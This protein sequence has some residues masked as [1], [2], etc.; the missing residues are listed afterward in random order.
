M[1]GKTR[2]KRAKR[3]GGRKAVRDYVRAIARVALARAGASGLRPGEVRRGDAG[4]CVAV[5]DAAA[6]PVREKV[7][8][9]DL[10]AERAKLS[11]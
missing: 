1:R 2:R 11:A 5:V 10:D 7:L 6:N 4:W 8:S 3:D 9:F